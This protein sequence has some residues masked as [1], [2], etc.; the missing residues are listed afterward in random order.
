MS[1][2]TM[3]FPFHLQLFTR[4]LAQFSGVSAGSRVLDVGCGIGGTA[5]Y[6]ARNLDCR[7]TAVT[8]SRRQVEVARQLTVIEVVKM[9]PAKTAP[10][11][12]RSSS[13]FLDVVQMR[14]H[15]ADEPFDCVWVSEVV[16]QLHD[17]KLFFD[18]ALA[19]L[20]HRGCLRTQKELASIRRN[21][22][23]PELGTVE[24]YTQVAQ[25]AGLQPRNE[26]IDITKNLIIL[27]RDT[28]LPIGSILYLISRGRDTIGYMR[29]M[30]STKRAC[31]NGTALYAVL[32][33]E[34]P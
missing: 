29:E 24:E 12:N 10:G 3:P 2:D 32:C 19:L 33:F 21:H 25:E 18:S 1:S 22:L 14:G 28:S 15:P 20:D 9:P 17:R 34:K 16:C 26:L 31:A 23:C 7:V 27:V 13:D 8:N 4:L 11:Q 5:R 6:L 30:R